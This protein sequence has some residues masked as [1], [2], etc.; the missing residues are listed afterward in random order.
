[1]L[2]GTPSAPQI[3]LP[4]CHSSGHC[5]HF[6]SIHDSTYGDNSGISSFSIPMSLASSSQVQKGSIASENG[7]FF[8]KY[9]LHE[10]ELSGSAEN[11]GNLDEGQ[12][13]ASFLH[14]RIY[15]MSCNALLPFLQDCTRKNDLEG[16]R[17]VY[18]LLQVVELDSAAILEDYLIRLFGCCGSLEEA[19]YVFNHVANPTV[20]TWHAIIS[21]Y[22]MHG[23]NHKSVDLFYRMLQN[24]IVPDKYIYACIIKACS[25]LRSLRQGMLI[26][27]QIVNCGLESDF[28]IGSALLDMYSKCDLV[29]AVCIEFLRLPKLSAVSWNVM[30][31]MFVERG[32][33]RMALELFDQMQNEG[34]SPSNATYPSILKACSCVRAF[35]QGKAIHGQL[36]ERGLIS[37]VYI[38]STLIDMYASCGKM[39][40]AFIEFSKFSKRNIVSWCTI[41]AAAAQHGL[42]PLAMELY[43][44]MGL[45]C[46]EIDDI[47]FVCAIKVC[48][49]LGNVGQGMSL[50]IQVVKHGLDLVQMVGNSLVS[51]YSKCGYVIDAFAVFDQLPARNVVS[52]AAMIAGYSQNGNSIAA[53]RLFE[54]MK[55]EKVEADRVTFMEVL[56]AC[57]SVGAL[58]QGKIIHQQLI[59]NGLTSDV[60]V[61]STLINMYSRC[62]SLQEACI[63]FRKLPRQDVE[64]WGM[65]IAGYARTGNYGLALSCLNDMQEE[66]FHPDA[67]IF[68]SVLAACRHAGQVKEG[69]RQ[70]KTMRDRHRIMPSIEH[71]GCMIDLLGRAGHLD[72]AEEL[73]DAMPTPPD[74]NG[75]MSLLIAC[76]KYGRLSLGKRSFD[77]VMRLDPS[78][79][80]GFMAMSSIYADAQLWENLNELEQERKQASAWKKPGRAWIEVKNK[81]HEFSV[82]DMSHPQIDKILTKL[83][84]MKYNMD[85]GCVPHSKSRKS[86]QD[87]MCGHCERLAIAFGLLSAP[88]GTPIRVTKNLQVCRDCHSATKR[89]SRIESRPII[90]SDTY[91]VHKFINGECSCGDSF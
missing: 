54:K 16:G 85:D 59:E 88:E 45:E 62:G 11:V 42:E 43:G 6:I 70:F 55:S 56:D 7:S 39:D 46:S 82:G 12:R 38:G 71:F 10:E 78:I 13:C 79:S 73:L 76:K 15:P 36:I 66:G 51:M 74:L 30:I 57:A 83:Q 14:G 35:E 80:A 67:R 31:T 18:S 58:G 75:W 3:S 1:M 87:G 63:V 86:K 2:L 8:N 77:Q 50:H 84:S 27:S 9:L 81:I 34:I 20:Y 32:E 17:L 41:I 91:F 65:L 24:N 52:W 33:G 26:H 90:I 72:E 23:H 69:Y 25:H 5:T 37:D 29:E 89:M 48:A 64:L 19:E 61:G 40:E 49:T 68:T 53:L 60:R 22:S 28:F 47:T 4:L 21:T 44:K